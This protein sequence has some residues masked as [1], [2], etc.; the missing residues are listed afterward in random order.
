[1]FIFMKFHIIVTNLIPNL[2][3]WLQ[4]ENIP[5]VRRP[6]RKDLL[7]YLNGEACE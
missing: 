3:F 2:K 7:G 5:V 1:M 4:T 6:D